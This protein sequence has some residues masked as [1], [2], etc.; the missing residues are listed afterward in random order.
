MFEQ[1]TKPDAPPATNAEAAELYEL[2][3]AA[4]EQKLAVAASSRATDANELDRR[5]VEQ[6]D[7]LLAMLKS[8]A[9]EARKSKESERAKAALQDH[10]WVQVETKGTWID[11]DPLNPDGSPNKS[12]T[13]AKETL[14]PDSL[15]QDQKHRVQLRVVAEQ[16][17]DGKLSENSIFEHDFDPSQVIGK[18]IALRHLPLLWPSDWDAITPDDVQEKLFA[19]LLT[20]KEW[21][22]SLTVDGEGYQQASILDTGALNPDPQP[23]SNPFLS[24]AF[25]AA[26]KVG[27][28]ADLFD[29]M[30][31]E[32]A[33][34][35]DLEKEKEAGEKARTEGELTAEWLEYTIDI[36]GEEPKTV[37]REIFDILGPALRQSGETGQFPP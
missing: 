31:A 22:P 34:P 36:P 4:A 19:A 25:P 6:G 18:R 5:T 12:M 8:E 2:D 3:K 17:R 23:R 32:Q 33:S 13:A 11:Y 1:L 30:L 20:Q 24:L 27:R 14:S 7:R 28:V 9:S 29:Q 35:E 15:P 37:R 26:G 21:M 10:W 16:L